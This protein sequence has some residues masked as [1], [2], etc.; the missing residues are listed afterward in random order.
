MQLFV[1]LI[2]ALWFVLVPNALH[3]HQLQDDEPRVIDALDGVFAAFETHSIVALG[4]QHGIREMGDF[5]Q[6]LL[7]DPRFVE[8]VDAVVLE[9]GNAFFQDLI[10]RYMNG[11]DIPYHDLQRVWSDAVGKIPGGTEVL[12]IQLFT[13][14]RAINLSLP[15]SER[16]RVLLGD[17]PFDWSTAQTREDVM[18]AQLQRETHYAQV[19]IDEVLAQGL[20]GLIITGYPHLDR[21]SAAPTMMA[22]P[23]NEQGGEKR[24]PAA[25]P[26]IMQQIIEAQYPGETFVIIL[27]TGFADEACNSEL[28]A[29]MASWE[30]P[31]LAY[32]A[33][34]WLESI[35]CAKFPA[36]VMINPAQAGQN[37]MVAPP[38]GAV[39]TV[40][41]PPSSPIPNA[42]AYLYLGNR[43]DLT[44]SPFDPIIYLDADYF[45][46]MSRRRELMTGLP[47]DWSD[48]I[49]DNPHYYVDNFPAL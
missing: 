48:L 21:G 28:E 1:L 35:T 15:E 45:A 5:Y 44:M 10:D 19:V 22:V 36:A 34:S 26:M 9:Y 27:H 24:Q 16:I 30:T 14:L 7:N 11:E 25:P 4:E 8:T 13:T 6:A 18:P 41:M 32:V 46:E 33:G 29:R 20:K 37:N 17:P 42:D 38:E 40:I 47:L 49:Q 39:Q 43:D 23:A 12:Y 31:S 3:A 2:A